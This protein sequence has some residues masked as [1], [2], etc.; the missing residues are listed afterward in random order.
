MDKQKLIQYIS[1]NKSLIDIQKL[2]N[3][4]QSTIRY[5]LKKFGLK[6]NFVNFK[7]GYWKDKTNIS[8]RKQRLVEICEPEKWT[9][10]QKCSYSYLLG[11]YLGDG[12]IVERKNRKDNFYFRIFQDSKYVNLIQYCRQQLEV[13]FPKNKTRLLNQN[14]CTVIIIAK[15][16]L[17]HW[18]PQHGPGKK[19]NRDIILEK[20]QEEILEK[21][22]KDFIKGLIHSDGSRYTQTQGKY[23]SIFYN[24]TNLSKDIMNLFQKYL[25]KLDIKYTSRVKTNGKQL[26]CEIRRK[27]EVLKLDEFIGPKS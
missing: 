18:F 14:N 4:S 23:I 24:F 26:M 5:W 21:Y 20:W 22:S 9:E 27:K 2:E 7:S 16:N 17:P 11:L 8:F 25:D 6:T 19:H 12:H 15:K 13:L 1:E 3:K 10:N